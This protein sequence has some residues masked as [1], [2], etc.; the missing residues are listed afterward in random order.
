MTSGEVVGAL[1]IGGTHSSAAR[2][3]LAGGSIEPQSRMRV[4][5]PADGG[6][7]ELRAAISRVASSIAR[8][9]VR[10]LGVAVPGPFD[11]STG[12]SRITHKLQALY[13]VDLRSDLSG[14][15]GLTDPAAVC[16]L[17][18]ADA[19]LLVTARG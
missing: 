5:L 6:R 18:D 15:V 12:V 19:F 7:S 4:S 3:D 14:A 13:G 9:E 11:Y 2:V 1:E 17:N 10:R 16:F 8:P